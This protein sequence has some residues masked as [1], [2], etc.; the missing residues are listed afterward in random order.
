[1]NETATEFYQRWRSA[2][3]N[4]KSVDEITAFWSAETIDQFNMEPDAARAET[5][6]MVKRFYSMHTDVKVVKETATP[7]GATLSLEALDR[8]GKPVVGSVDVVKE[9][10]ACKMSAAVEQWHPKRA[11]EARLAMRGARLAR[12]EARL[13]VAQ[14]AVRE[15]RLAARLA[16]C[17]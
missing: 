10:G 15:A 6:T 4:A 9:T 8:D 14:L 2:A 17:G 16:V 1:M 3:V 11:A 5:L 12:R 13:A 7:S